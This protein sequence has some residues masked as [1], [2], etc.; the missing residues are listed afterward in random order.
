METMNTTEKI[1]K[2]NVQKGGE[3]MISVIFQCNDD[4]TVHYPVICNEN[5]IFS[6]VEKKLYE[7]YPQYKKTTNFFM[8]NGNTVD[9]TKNMKENK[10]KHGRLII[11][12]IY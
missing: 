2:Q 6:E 5:Q 3:N 4:Q 10:L 8:C 12:K 1:N 9:K 7:E 11:M